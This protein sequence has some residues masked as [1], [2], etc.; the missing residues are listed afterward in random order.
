VTTKKKK[1][2]KEVTSV[3]CRTGERRG[4]DIGQKKKIDKEA[5]TA[6]LMPLQK[7]KKK[8]PP[9][10]AT[11]EGGVGSEGGGP[12]GQKGGKRDSFVPWKSLKKGKK[13]SR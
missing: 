3:A 1:K 10:L 8:T 4:K 13:D 11:Q 6:P 12:S 7:E 2:E 9:S 5:Q